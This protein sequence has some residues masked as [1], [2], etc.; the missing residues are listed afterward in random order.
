MKLRRFNADGIA[1]FRDYRSR[2]TI[3]SLLPP[4]V[5]LL[6]DAAYTEVVSETDVSSRSFASRLEAGRFFEEL[7]GRANVSSPECDQGLWAWLTLFYFDEVCPPIAPAV[8]TQKP[9]KRVLF[10]V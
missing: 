10:R 4:P 9:M 7:L 3:E 1:A 8:V 5:Q 6:E 2:L